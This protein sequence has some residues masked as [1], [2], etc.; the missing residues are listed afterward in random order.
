MPKFTIWKK[1]KV[2]VIGEKGTWTPAT[3]NVQYDVL[4]VA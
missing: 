3:S 2:E 1:S 4:D